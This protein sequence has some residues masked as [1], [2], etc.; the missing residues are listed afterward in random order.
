MTDYSRNGKFE[1]ESRTSH[2]YIIR[3]EEV[4]AYLNNCTIPASTRN[5]ELNTALKYTVDYPEGNSIEHIIAVDGENTTLPI[6]E[7]FPSSL[8]TFFQFGSIVIEIKD[9]QDMEKKPF[10]SPEDIKKLKEIKREKLVLPTKNISLVGGM[11]FKTVVRTA[12]QDFFRKDHAWNSPMLETVYWFLFETYNPAAVKPVHMLSQCPQC[13]TRDIPLER[14]KMR[15]EYS[16]ACTHHL[17]RKEIFLT[18]VFKLFERVD[19]ETGAEAI[20]SMLRGVVETFL[21][22]HAI[23]QLIDIEEGLV[24]QFLFVK[25]GPLS[26]SGETAPMQLPMLKLLSYLSKTNNRINLVGVEAGGSFVE[27]AKQIRDKIKPGEVFLLNNAH[28]YRYVLVGDSKSQR[29]GE[30]TY[31]GGKIIYKSLD[32]RIYVL[33]LPVDNPV[34][35]YSVPELKDLKN[36]QEVLFSVARLRCDIYENALIPIAVVNKMISLSTQAG[37]K[38]LEK[39]AKKTVQK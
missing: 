19:N 18:D 22:L 13:G 8:L 28:I 7:G 33:T 26:F 2:S 21:I 6:N 25:D 38:I 3:D 27:H 10:V 35:Y 23:R 36:L 32:E 12:I 16:W 20:V 29:Y 5:V 15:P 39:F 30:S 34:T 14:D 31:Y 24:S 17:C 11:D 9:L 37:T 1:R 4:Q